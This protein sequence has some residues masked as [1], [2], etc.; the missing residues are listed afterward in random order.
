[1][2]ID[3][4]IHLFMLLLVALP[5]L[6]LFYELS[7]NTF[8]SKPLSPYVDYDKI[9]D[10]IPSEDASKLKSLA[11][12]LEIRIESLGETPL[13][14]SVMDKYLNQWKEISDRLNI[15]FG[16]LGLWRHLV[17]KEGINL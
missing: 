17:M 10:S 5:F 2:D 1:M 7:K 14:K 12:A 11:Y 3:N 6:Y 4:I 13:P 16:P 9:L 15:P 8:I